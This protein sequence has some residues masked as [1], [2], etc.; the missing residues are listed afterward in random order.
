M[1]NDFNPDEFIEEKESEFN[2]D[3]FIQEKEAGNNEPAVSGKYS[4]LIKGVAE[5]LPMAGAV[6]GGALGS[7]VAP[8]VGTVGGAAVG[9][10]LGKS[11]ENIIESKILGEDKARSE[12][13]TDPIL[14]AGNSAMMEGAGKAI[15]KAGEAISEIPLVK[16]GIEKLSS[17]ATKVAASLTGLAEQE[18]KTFAK[19]AE[20][21]KQMFKE[22]DGS[23]FEAA[24]QL[25]QG[26]AEKVTAF[27]KAMN[28][29]IS[30]TLKSSTKTVELNPIKQALEQ[31][32]LK[33]NGKLYPEQIAQIDELIKKAE[34]LAEKG[35][36]N[37]SDAND[38]KHFLQEKA[39]SA[40]SRTGE[41]FSLGT[42]AAKAAKTGAA[43][44]RK[45]V[46]AAESSVANANNRLSFLHDIEDA[47]NRNILKV[48]TP[49]ASILGAGTGGNQ[50]NAKALKRL[51]DLVDHDVLGDSQNLAAMRSFGSPAWLPV[52]GTGK[53]LT[54]MGVGAGIGYVL[55]DEKSALAGAA[56][57]SPAAL[58]AIIG[59]GK[60]ASSRLGSGVVR[61]G[62]GRALIPS[63]PE[64]LKRPTPEEEK[65]E[66]FLINQTMPVNP[67]DVQAMEQ[68]LQK[69]EMT[70]MEKAKRLNLL[71]KHGRMAVGQ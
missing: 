27:R 65:I 41:M 5:A 37:V 57:T 26:W 30:E 40:Y 25:R 60:A 9:G 52:D 51:G 47:M 18:I 61:Q 38:L 2:P 44:A 33:I 3:E 69:S 67:Q 16:K 39:A 42:E 10:A 4:G 6:G 54:R 11:L 29:Q 21:I 32:K 59:L 53:S 55:G 13:M 68:A 15:G 58:K 71:R 50:R 46:N 56:M 22:S 28:D 62:A 19:H 8:M 34:S 7:M 23:T 35:K 36:I 31:G 49:E 20:K 43:A 64:L 70:N 66:G 14:E 63:I 48:G 12:V 45:L 24:E 1:T 17:G